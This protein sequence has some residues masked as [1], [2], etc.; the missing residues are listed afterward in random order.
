MTDTMA[1]A[2][3]PSIIVDNRP[4]AAQFSEAADLIRASS[5]VAL[6][7]HVQPDG[8]ALGSMLGM[9]HALHEMGK[10]V[11]PTVDGGCPAEYHFL[12]NWEWIKPSLLGEQFDLLISCDSSDEKR[13]GEAGKQA[14]AQM[15][16]SIN[17]DHHVTNTDFATANIWN[18]RY[19]STTETVLRLLDYIQHPVSKN[20]ANCLFCGLVTDSLGFRIS[21]V[22]PE[23]FSQAGRLLAAGADLNRTM[24]NTLN[25]M[26]TAS[27]RLWANALPSLKIEDHV[28]WTRITIDDQR[29]AG[30]EQGESSGNLVSLLLQADEVFVA[31]TLKEKINI[32]HSA[33]VEVSLRSKPGFNVADIAFALGG[34]GHTQAAGA[35]I[36]ATL[37]SVEVKLIPLLKQ[38]AAAG[39]RQY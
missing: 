16:P 23:T 18:P 30:I 12:P 17:L 36:P 5:R 39:T 21:A 26:S 38:A 37:E 19:V 29:T 13:T 4:F 34:G 32:N 22:K 9:A 11:I 33:E 25:R 24:E 10:Q 1:D 3:N 27:L 35:T 28:A 2:V 31:A 14:R 8:D 20:V 6:I 15:T 7:T